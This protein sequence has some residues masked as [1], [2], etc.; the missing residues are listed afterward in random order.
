MANNDKRVKDTE[1]LLNHTAFRLNGMLHASS[2]EDRP[3][4]QETLAD[5]SQAESE[6]MLQV[7]HNK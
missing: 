4:V 6:A 5:V 3:L 7:F 2:F 1:I